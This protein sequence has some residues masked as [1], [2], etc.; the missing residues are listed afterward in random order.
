[1]DRQAAIPAI[2]T[3]N[4][5]RAAAAAKHAYIS[6]FFDLHLRHH[7]ISLLNRPSPAYPDIQ[8]VAT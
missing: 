7:D 2:G 8:F 4:P 1:M 5:A 3:I 6:A